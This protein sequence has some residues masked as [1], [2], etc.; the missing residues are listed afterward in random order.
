MKKIG[1]IILLIIGYMGFS[2]PVL[3]ETNFPQTYSANALRATTS[4]FTNGPSGMNVVWDYSAIPFV[5]TNYSMSLV[6][7]ITT[8][9]AAAFPASNYCYRFND[10]GTIF[11]NY[12]NLSANAMEYL[13]YDYD[14]I[15]NPFINTSTFLEFPYQYNSVITDIYQNFGST[16]IR[17][18]VRTYDGYGTLK[19]PFGDFTNVI[20]QKEVGDFGTVY[21]WMTTNPYQIV[22]SGN[23]TEPTI[24]FYQPTILANQQQN[25]VEFSV[26]PNPTA[27]EFAINGY[28]LETISV[29]VYNSLGQ[30]VFND[31]AYQIGSEI[32][33]NACAKGLYF[34]SAT[35]QNNTLLFF[36]D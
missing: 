30:G 11:Y 4:G 26:Y 9:A 15:I 5:T 36:S 1:F 10:N 2:Q 35:D 7:T 3:N 18:A 20:R 29:T 34:I 27:G 8:P 24:L 21:Y 25:A 6:P 31:P 19:T 17:T 32:N 13:G 22:L 16:I 23:F 33:L 12:Y 28:T 14:G